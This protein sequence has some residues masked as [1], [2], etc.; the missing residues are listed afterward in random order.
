MVVGR[1]HGVHPLVV[2]H[3][4]MLAHLL[5]SEFHDIYFVLISVELEHIIHVYV[6]FVHDGVKCKRCVEGYV[7]MSDFQLKSMDKIAESGTSE[8]GVARV[9][10][11][12]DISYS[13]VYE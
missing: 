3:L 8:E 1:L 12:C 2:A 7:G 11:F 13:L 4:K 9:N 6:S 10:T 5:S